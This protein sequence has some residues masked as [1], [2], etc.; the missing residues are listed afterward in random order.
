MSTLETILGDRLQITILRWLSNIQRPMS[1]NAIARRLEIPQSSARLALERLVDAGII[2]RTDIGRS[3]GYTLN[4]RLAV[5]QRIILPLF[6][7]EAQLRTTLLDEL[8]QLSSTLVHAIDSPA[9]FVALF[10]SLARGDRAYRDIDLLVVHPSRDHY[11]RLR[12]IIVDLARPIERRFG[13]PVRPVL[14]SEADLDTGH[15]HHLAVEVHIDG[16]ALA[17]V[18][19]ATLV[20]LSSYTPASA[21]DVA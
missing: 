7:R 14:V 6:K 2:T 21:R 20:G 13:V 10:G 1:G 4:D 9:T 8:A 18:P 11:E 16:V 5:V 15:A 17:G 19:P 12:D 3:A